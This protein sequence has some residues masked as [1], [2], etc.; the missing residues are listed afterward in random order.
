[1]IRRIDLAVIFGAPLVGAS[2]VVLLMSATAARPASPPPANSPVAAVAVSPSATVSVAVSM[3][4]LTASPTVGATASQQVPKETPKEVAPT[5]TPTPR[6]ATPAPATQA[7]TAE[8]T[9]VPA[10]PTPGATPTPAGPAM[11]ARMTVLASVTHNDH[12]YPVF[13]IETLPGAVCTAHA[14]RADNPL[15]WVTGTLP[16]ALADGRVHSH[17]LAQT[18]EGG[19]W[20][21]SEGTSGGYQL[22]G[23]CNNGTRA[24]FGF[25]FLWTASG[26]IFP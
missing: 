1:V 6:P 11:F 8:P 20:P 25:G 18:W 13:Q 16:A 22:Y 2:V 9:P 5:K 26:P 17:W 19:A 12:L 4:I 24:N 7:P 15:A 21:Y 10:T 14:E 23:Y 3:G